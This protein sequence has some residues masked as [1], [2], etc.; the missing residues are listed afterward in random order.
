MCKRMVNEIILSAIHLDSSSGKIAQQ[1]KNQMK[2]IIKMKWHDER[3][4]LRAVELETP[5][6]S[7]HYT[8]IMVKSELKF[9][10]TTTTCLYYIQKK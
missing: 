8:R 7:L 9:H 10:E 1:K 3:N 6:D 5:Q 4:Q 2:M